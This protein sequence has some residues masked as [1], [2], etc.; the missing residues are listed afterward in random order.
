MRHILDGTIARRNFITSLGGVAAVS[1]MP[2]KEARADALEAALMA[3]AET[4]QSAL[5]PSSQSCSPGSIH[6]PTVAEIEAQ[7]PTRSYRRAVGSLLLSTHP[8]GK[9]PLLA[10]TP[11]RSTL[12]DFFELRFKK[13]RNHCLQSA[14]KALQ[15]GA[16]EEVILACLVHDTVRE[17][18]HTDYGRCGTQLYEPYLP[19]SAPSGW[20]H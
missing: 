17:L 11:P 1:R 9:V 16:D 4:P 3:G 7:V 19:A 10:P 13:S 2:H 6:F 12:W 15:A 5:Y 8:D 18:I 14:N 20:R